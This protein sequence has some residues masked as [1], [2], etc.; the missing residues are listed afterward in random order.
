MARGAKTTLKITGYDELLQDIA[1]MEKDV[2]EA[3]ESALKKAGDLAV[4]EYE[5]V[6]EEHFYAGI[7]KESIVT[8]PKIQKEGTKIVMRTGYDIK[9]GGLASIYLDKGT[10]KQRPINYMAKIKRNRKIKNAIG[11]D[12]QKF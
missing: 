8:S 12:L 10:P 3:V 2:E 5:K 1:D 11:E 4:Q 6:A 9:A 7:T